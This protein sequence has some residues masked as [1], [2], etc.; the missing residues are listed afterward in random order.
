MKIE[1]RGRQPHQSFAIVP[2]DAAR[3]KTLSFRSRGILTL[4]LS[5]DDGFNITADGVAKEG[6]E[7]RDA[8]R[9]SF[10]ELE[11]AGYIRRTKTRDPETGRLSG[12]VYL[13]PNGNANEIDPDV[14]VAEQEDEPS[15]EAADSATSTDDSPGTDF[16]SSGD[17]S[18]AGQSY[19]ED[20]QEDQDA[21]AVS[22]EGEQQQQPE[23]EREELLVVPCDNDE[24][25]SAHAWW[26][27]AAPEGGYQYQRQ[28][29]GVTV[30]EIEQAEA[31]FAEA[32]AAAA[33][34]KPAETMEEAVA[35]IA[36]TLG[37]TVV[38]DTATSHRETHDPDGPRVQHHGGQRYTV[39]DDPR[40]QK[41][42]PAVAYRNLV[43]WWAPTQQ[44]GEGW[45]AAWQAADMA[46]ARSV[47]GDEFYYDPEAHL[48][49]YLSRCKAEN[50]KP[51]GDLWLRFYIEDRAKHVQTLKQQREQAEHR[52]E[53]PQQRE[54]RANSSLP[55][56][57]WGPPE[58][59]P[60]P[61]D[62]QQ[63]G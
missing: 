59:P 9:A 56:A 10:K 12:K 19:K 62:Y 52:A 4:L 58:E 8:V 38:A 44:E 27:E 46:T 26:T 23:P 54:D 39:A 49:M 1:R 42:F 11:A 41:P 53:D 20:H 2:N 55:P 33:S 6:V 7:G 15:D 28:C 31:D 50:R 35:T 24:P 36:D 63:E 60:F 16:Q 40:Q 51:R 5:H 34:E 48:M 3:D 45:I 13:Y 25:H 17:Q 22:T 43:Q 21:A 32:K 37:G 30:E 61:D 14:A 57:D 47:E 18:Q 29:D